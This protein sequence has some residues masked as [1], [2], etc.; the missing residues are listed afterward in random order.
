[1]Y[2][3]QDMTDMNM[4]WA[5][6]A[7]ANISNSED[8]IKWVRLLFQTNVVL[9][10][11]QQ[12][13]LTSLVC[14]GYVCHGF[15]QGQVCHKSKQFGK[16]IVTLD[17][18]CNVGFGLGVAEELTSSDGKERIYDGT[19]PGYNSYY[20]FMEKYNI[21]ITAQGDGESSI[22]ELPYEILLILKKYHTQP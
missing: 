6:A 18:A 16:P 17:D 22:D 12:G 19:T 1:V 4:S 11:V 15:G 20:L 5:S 14:V 13:E 9:P 2:P 10:P 21:V 8:L 3:E 7:G